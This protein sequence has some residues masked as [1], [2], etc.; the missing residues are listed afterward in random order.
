MNVV[1]SRK[2]GISLLEHQRLFNFSTIIILNNFYKNLLQSSLRNPPI[3]NLELI[4]FRLE[5]PEHLRQIQPL[6]REVEAESALEF[7]CELRRGEDGRDIFL[8]LTLY[9]SCVL[10]LVF[11]AV[12]EE[13]VAASILIL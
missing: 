12:Y 8:D 6:Q 7:R 2:L 11:L 1:I 10:V 3:R 13:M 4:S 5:L 9:C